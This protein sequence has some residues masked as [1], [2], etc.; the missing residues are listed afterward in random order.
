[1]RKRAKT[2]WGETPKRVHLRVQSCGRTLVCNV[3]PAR[4]SQLAVCVL[5]AAPTALLCLLSSS[6][7]SSVCFVCTQHCT[8]IRSYPQQEA[9]GSSLLLARATRETILAAK[10]VLCSA[11]NVTPTSSLHQSSARSLEPQ[12]QTEADEP[13]DTFEPPNASQLHHTHCSLKTN[14]PNPDRHN[15]RGKE[16]TRRTKRGGGGSRRKRTRLQ[17]LAISRYQRTPRQ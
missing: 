16:R 10:D 1:M 9:S 14:E 4:S 6:G 12:R 3:P 17:R 7:F 8:A 5:A 13:L 11:T 15:E 2:R